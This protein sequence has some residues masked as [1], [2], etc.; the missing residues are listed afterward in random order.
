M[1]FRSE[2]FTDIIDWCR[3]TKNEHFLWF[4][5]LIENHFDGIV[6]YGLYPISSG[7]IEGINAH[8]KVIRRKAYGL[9]DDEYF[10]LKIMDASRNP[11][12]RI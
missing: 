4:A 12:K 1:L 7:K 2:K 10:F 6:G 5:R 3:G 11:Y 9:P 8:I